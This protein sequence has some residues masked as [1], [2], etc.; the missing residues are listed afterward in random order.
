M[1]AHSVNHDTLSIVGNIAIDMHYERNQDVPTPIDL[2]PILMRCKDAPDLILCCDLHHC[3]C[4]PPRPWADDPFTTALLACSTNP[5]LANV[6]SE[7][8]D[9]IELHYSANKKLVGRK[10]RW[11]KWTRRFNRKLSWTPGEMPKD[12]IASFADLGLP[13]EQWGQGVE[14]VRPE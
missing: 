11:K 2:H 12:V 3:P 8:F 14:F 10:G 9:A 4:C 6:L 5:N 7:A 1:L 13:V